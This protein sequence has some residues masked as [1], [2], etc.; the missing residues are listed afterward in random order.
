MGFIEE[1][2]NQHQDDAR[3]PYTTDVIGILCLHGL[4][5]TKMTFAGLA[6]EVGVWVGALVSSCSLTVR[7]KLISSLVHC[8]DT[9]STAHHR[10]LE[11]RDHTA[12][13]HDGP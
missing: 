4:A 3:G 12:K 6:R 11:T 10:T 7:L 2:G 1:D 8:T 13:M 9:E 5:S